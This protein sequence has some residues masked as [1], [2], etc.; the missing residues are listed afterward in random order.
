MHIRTD[1][2]IEFTMMKKKSKQDQYHNTLRKSEEFMDTLQL[3]KDIMMGA[4]K[5]ALTGNREAWIENYRG[6]LEYTDSCIRLQGKHGQV[7]IEGKALCIEYYTNEDLK[8]T[9]CF[10]SIKF[11]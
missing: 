7:R 1:P 2:V 4:M 11:E 6:L 3:P 8:I 9:G 5:I 10:S